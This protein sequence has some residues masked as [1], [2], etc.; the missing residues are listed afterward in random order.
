[1]LPNFFY[2]EQ[3]IFEREKKKIFLD[4]WIFFCFLDEV[5]DENDFLRKTIFGENVFV[6]NRG[7]ELSGFFNFCPHRFHPLVKADSG[8]LSQLVCDY[9]RWSF[10]PDGSL[11]NIPFC[12]EAYQFSRA[13]QASISLSRFHVEVIG[14]FVFVNLAEKPIAIAKQFSKDLVGLLESISQHVSRVHAVSFEK[15]FNW[16]LIQ[17]NLRDPLHPTF[18]HPKTLAK[19]IDTG[20]PGIPR[21]IPFWA[22]PLRRASYGGPDVALLSAPPYQDRFLNPWP[23]E[24]RY[25]NYWLYPNL[26]LAGPDGGLTFMLESFVPLSPSSTR[27]ELHYLIGEN[28]FTEA[29]YD[30]FIEGLTQNAMRVYEEDFAVLEAIQQAVGSH[31]VRFPKN[32]K[33]ERMLTRFHK[34]YLNKTGYWTKFLVAKLIKKIKRI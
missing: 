2:V 34:I 31:V 11:A 17:E 13:E 28:D 12:S 32:G 16:K 18:V 8:K 27:V 25:H 9:H 3:A 22:L 21:D 26:H 30:E 24:G 20:V 10:K 15:Q 7:G 6:V 23:C 1:M 14:K 4:S 33:F 29:Q 5:S 19:E